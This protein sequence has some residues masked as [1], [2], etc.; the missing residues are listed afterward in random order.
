MDAISLCFFHFIHRVV[1]GAIVWSTG[2]RCYR[3]PLP[4]SEPPFPTNVAAAVYEPTDIASSGSAGEEKRASRVA[5]TLHV[6]ELRD[7]WHHVSVSITH[8]KR[9]ERQKKDEKEFATSRISL[10]R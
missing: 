2:I 5:D 8:F 9:H 4:G 1:A 10:S 6:V 3:A 7:A